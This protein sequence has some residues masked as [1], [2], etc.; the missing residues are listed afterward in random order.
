MAE[1]GT[2]ADHVVVTNMA[3][4]LQRDIMIVTS[5][6]SSSGNEC[7]MWV[8]GDSSGK[9]D[10]LL[11]AH[12]WENHYQSLQPIEST[13]SSLTGKYDGNFKGSPLTGNEGFDRH[14]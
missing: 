14:V 8:S 3:K 4:M 6:P 13:V 12:M 7:L 2:W 10:P 5:S 11:L 1:G 9:K